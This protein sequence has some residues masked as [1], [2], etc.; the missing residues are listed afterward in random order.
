MKSL[1]QAGRLEIQ[2]KA[3]AF[4]SNLKA[5]NTGKISVL[6]SGSRNP[7]LGNLKGDHIAPEALN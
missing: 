3:D 1:G 6:P 7:S 4:V 5:R 2:V